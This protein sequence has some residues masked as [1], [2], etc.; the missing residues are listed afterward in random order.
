[1]GAIADLI[2]ELYPLPDLDIP[3]LIIPSSDPPESHRLAILVFFCTLGEILLQQFLERCMLRLNLPTQIQKRLLQDNLF[4]P[5]RIERLFPILTGASWKQAVSAASKHAE[6]NFQST[7]IFYKE[8]SE[9]RNLLLHL[10]NK[11]AVP[12]DMARKCF[13]QIA[14]LIKLFVELHNTCLAKPL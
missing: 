4:P 14:P 5:Q 3:V 6:T 13:D 8:A 2:A 11:W 1:V 10:G 9:G 12:T 7:V